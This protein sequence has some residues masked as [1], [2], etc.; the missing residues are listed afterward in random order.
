MTFPQ[1]RRRFLD[2]NTNTNTNTNS[3]SN[4]PVGYDGPSTAGADGRP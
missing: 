2:S 1:W 3:G 4:L